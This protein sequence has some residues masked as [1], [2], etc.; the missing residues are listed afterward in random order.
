MHL[1]LAQATGGIASASDYKR[2]RTV[3]LADESTSSPTSV[4]SL[5]SLKWSLWS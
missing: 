5:L 4:T 2:V 3:L 1:M